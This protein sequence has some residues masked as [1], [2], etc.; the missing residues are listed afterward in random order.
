MG[1]DQKLGAAH[2]GVIRQVPTYPTYLLLQRG[3]Q[4]LTGAEVR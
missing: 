2:G 3:D 4:L 1:D